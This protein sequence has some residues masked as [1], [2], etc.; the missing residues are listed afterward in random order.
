MDPQT[1]LII[2]DLD[3][4]TERKV[5]SIGLGAVANL[6]QDTPRDTGWARSN[7]I[8][9]KGRPPSLPDQP[10]GRPTSGDVGQAQAAQAAGAASLLSYRLQDGPVYISNHVPYI[11][12]LNT[13]TS[14]QAGS[15]FVERAV[16]RAVREGR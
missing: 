12:S 5:T 6:R 4:F 11:Q 13:G 15:E 10:S 16:E 8:S 7:W 14:K 1:H 2:R 9:A 3:R